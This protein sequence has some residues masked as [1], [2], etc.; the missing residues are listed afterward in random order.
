MGGEKK[1]RHEI[2]P[3]YDILSCH[4]ARPSKTEAGSF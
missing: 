1:E 2:F 3:A 4:S